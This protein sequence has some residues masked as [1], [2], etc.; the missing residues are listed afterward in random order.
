M[1]AS[2][3]CFWKLE[4]FSLLY[5]YF[6]FVDTEK[7]LADQLFIKNKVRVWFGPEYQWPD[8][9]YRIILCKC[10]KWDTDKFVAAAADLPN[11]MLLCGC[12]DY[13]TFCSEVCNLIDSR[14]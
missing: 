4:K 3:I 12:S 14:K 13:L 11:K 5:K 6:A 1:N 2:T 7:Y 10:Y 9:S 8:S